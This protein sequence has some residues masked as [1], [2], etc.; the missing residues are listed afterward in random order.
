MGNMKLEVG[1]DKARTRAEA[2]DSKTRQG[3]FKLKHVSNKARPWPECQFKAVTN[4]TVS[5]CTMW[6]SILAVAAFAGLSLAT[7]NI[8][9]YLPSLRTCF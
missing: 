2:D 9:V 3:D 4:M 7:F 5:A 6:P 8:K 1:F